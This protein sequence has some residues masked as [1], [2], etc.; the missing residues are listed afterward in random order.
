M[1][2]ADGTLVKA[3]VGEDSA[4]LPSLLTL[5]DVFLTG[6]HAAVNGRRR[7]PARPSR[8]SATAPS[9]CSAVLA[10]K[11]LGAEQIILM[12]RHKDRTDLGR[13]F[14]A[15]D[16]VAERGDEGVARVRE[17]TGGDGTHA[18]LECVGHMPAYE[19]AY[20]VVR[21][22]GVI[23]RVGVPQ[24]EEAPVGFGSLFGSNI[25]LTGGPGPACAPTSRSSSPR[26]S[27]A[28]S[29]PA[30]SSTAPS[31]STGCPRATAPWT[32]ARPSRSS[33]APEIGDQT[34]EILRR[35][36]TV[37]GP[38]EWFTGDV[39]FDVVFR[40]E[41][42][43]RTRVNTVRFAPCARTAWH[44]HANGQALHVTDGVGLVAVPR[45]RGDRHPARRR[46]L[47]AARRGALARRRPGPLH[48]AHRHLGGR[49][50]HVGRPRDRRR[51]RLPRRIRSMTMETRVL[52]QGLQVSALGLGCMGLSQ[53]YGPVPDRRE[54]VDL[55]RSAVDR[56]V[57]FFDTAEVYGPFVNE[58][59]VGEALQPVRDRVIIATKFGFA[60][61]ADGR[62]TGL[63]SRPEDIRR[64]AEGSLRRLGTDHIDLYYQ[65][66]VDPDVPIEDVAGAVKALIDEGK[67]RHFGLSE[68]SPRT[69]RRA[70]A[71]QPVTAL[72]S[73]YSL[74]FRTPEQE[75]L[76]TL[77]ELA[78]GFVPFSPL[79]KGFL[80]GTVD[81]STTF[82][83]DDIRSTIPRFTAEAREA[84]QALIDVLT[85]I[86]ERKQATT[87]Q[88]ALAW[89]LAQR[90]WIA[91]IPGTKRLS[92]LEEN[93][94]ASD[95][96]LTSGDL[97]EIDAAAARIEVQGARYPEHLERMVDRS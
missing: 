12:G 6:H 5:S 53:S 29:S 13:E 33:S 32:T 81:P 89:L 52:G 25:T 49:R 48:G 80:T 68:A 66:R 24:Y 23:S 27:T 90:P 97:A 1:P 35:Q 55:I 65:H 67:V 87:G 22:G 83:S 93:V 71:V 19:Q 59:L 58:E 78:I 96:E 76:P 14:G 74:W 4:L 16:V 50:D 91:P 72:Q 42:P 18:V 37:K 43:S 7:T 2:L 82:G 10:A 3:P 75:I 28:A 62:S 69:I 47:D 94:G 86:A 56:G 60:F 41:A 21:A 84:N 36:P 61:D 20:G 63:S 38:A 95:V 46:H 26:S 45:R 92:R 9:A 11:R 64:A 44:S 8:S 73:E 79:G 34:M 85:T 15:T 40:G 54:A 17:L 70:H 30:R 39:H 88:L 57:T 77:A 31:T 51:V